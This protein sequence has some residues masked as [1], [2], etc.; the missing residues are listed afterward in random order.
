LETQFSLVVPSLSISCGKAQ[1]IEMAH[2]P[3]S[4]ISGLRGGAEIPL[5]PPAH[6]TRVSEDCCRSIVSEA[7]RF[8]DWEVPEHEHADFCLHLQ[9]SGSPSHEWWWGRKHGIE[10]RAAGSLILLPPGT[11]DRV[12]WMG[13]SDSIIFSV[14]AKIVQDLAAEIAPSAR[15]TF[16]TRWHFRDEALRN[17]LAEIGRES[18]EGWPLGTLY[19]DLLGMS[20]ASLIL[21]RHTASPI[22]LPPIRGGMSI[23][24]MKSCMEFM[25][26]NM[27]RDISL[28]Q[29]ASVAG[30]S[31][32]HFARLF[33]KMTRQTPH[34]YRLDQRIRKAKHLLKE[35]SCQLEDIAG[36]VGFRSS[37]HF[38][39][40]FRSRE[41]VT[42]SA[43][44]RSC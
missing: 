9:R 7:H 15:P 35:T 39:H 13:P 29:V 14:E 12:R 4:R 37:A 17:V 31:T 8:Q 40:S 44:R 43:W 26:E 42:P 30:L 36:V 32:F 38:T 10:A 19:A 1:N 11:R 24:V 2:R 20:L 33:R 22:S 6:T 5:Y 16:L 21:R 18:S 27:H 28:D 25:T 23:C 34:Q 3:P 41:G